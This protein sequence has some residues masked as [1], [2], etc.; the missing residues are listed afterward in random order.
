MGLLH[1]TI[2]TYLK[3]QHVVHKSVSKANVTHTPG[4]LHNYE[5]LI[6]HKGIKHE[7]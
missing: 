1:M 4:T 3:Q 2:Q 7:N 5:K 6:M